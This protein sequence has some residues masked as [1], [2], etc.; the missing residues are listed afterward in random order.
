[1]NLT[2]DRTVGSIV[3]E[4]YRTAA[5]F[6]T[7]GIDFCCKGGRSIE[8]ACHEKGLDPDVLTREI[9][10]ALAR[11]WHAG[12]DFTAWEPS[13]LIEHIERVH[14]TYVS[15]RMPLL[16]QFLDK[17]CR[18]H[19]ERHPEL[20]TVSQEFHE[21]VAALT[22]H[23]KKEELI[24]FPYIQQLEKAVRHGVAPPRPHFG[25]VG[26]PVRMM[27]HEHTGEGERFHRIAQL[28]KGYLNPPDGCA[29]YSTAMAMLR[30]FEADLHLHIH[31]EN[32]ILFPRA[33]ALEKSL[34]P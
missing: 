2:P 24:L 5:V 23:M 4:D 21:C 20:H 14:H 9:E 34:N 16:V 11:G 19:G 13:R 10:A 30:D 27:E 29:T 6:N 7:H 25:S 8:A 22:A 31:L 18:V 33:I 15:Q 26:A 32:N 17:L 1:M 3:A 28:T 12:N